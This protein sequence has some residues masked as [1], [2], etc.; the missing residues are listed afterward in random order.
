MPST[1][2]YWKANHTYRDVKLSFNDLKQRG[3]R[4]LPT[5]IGSSFSYD[6]VTKKAQ[7]ALFR[8]SATTPAFSA[9]IDQQ[10]LKN[11]PIA[12]MFHTFL[13]SY[14]LISSLERSSYLDRVS[15]L[16]SPF[17]R[18]TFI[19]LMLYLFSTC[20]AVRTTYAHWI[21]PKPFG[22]NKTIL[23]KQ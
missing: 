17:S 10:A 19:S 18:A 7:V 23:L 20:S 15:W 9:L 5:T 4:L 1:S 12:F 13:C 11:W 22:N 16:T 2:C 6:A 8:V 21:I 3:L 14:P